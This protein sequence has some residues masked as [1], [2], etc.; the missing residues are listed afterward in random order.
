L[1]TFLGKQTTVV[2]NNNGANGVLLVNES[3]AIG[4]VA[5]RFAS[6][7]IL[8]LD[9]FTS[10][11]D[12]VRI[13]NYTLATRAKHSG[14]TLEINGVFQLSAP[15]GGASLT[16]SFVWSM[17]VTNVTLTTAILLAIDSNKLGSLPVG[18]MTNLTGIIP[19]VASAI[20]KL[21]VSSLSIDS[22]ALQA[23]VISGFKSPG[24]QRVVAQ[25]ADAI[26]AA[27]DEIA[28]TALS[29]MIESM[30][31]N[32]LD[33]VI[34]SLL[35]TSDCQTTNAQQNNTFVD[36]RNMFLSPQVA[37]NYGAS[38]TAP[39]GDLSRMIKDFVNNQFLAVSPYTNLT[40]LAEFLIVPMTKQQSGIAG[41]IVNN[42]L[43]NVYK[44]VNFGHTPLNVQ[45]QASNVRIDNLQSL[46][47]PLFLFVPERN[48]P[49]TVNNSIGF[50]LPPAPI[51]MGGSFLLGLATDTTKIH[52]EFVASVEI[53]SGQ[54]LIELWAKISESRLF[55]F[56][57]Q[58][59]LNLD[60]W[61]ATIPA[62]T[63]D[64]YG[65][66]LPGS[67]PTISVPEIVMA[68]ASMNFTLDCT[69]CSGL[70]FNEL[71]RTLATN[72]GDE[73]ATASATELINY[74]LAL[75][76]KESSWIQNTLD[77]K[78]VDAPR[79][80]PHSPEYIPNATS[81]QYDALASVHVPD[82]SLH[83]ILVLVIA[84]ASL[85]IF[86]MAITAS[87]HFVVRKR[88]E[89]WVR[90]LTSEQAMA[91]H[92]AQQREEEQA[93]AMN[94]SSLSLFRSQSIPLFV[95]ILVPIIIVAN[96]GLF[97]S[98]HFNKGKSRLH[99]SKPTAFV[100]KSLSTHANYSIL[101]VPRSEFI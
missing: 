31:M 26:Y 98:G 35:N 65:M 78:L 66:R 80:C 42:D 81:L 90:S 50:G 25:S 75:A 37:Q 71:S 49:F 41:T 34:N 24:L 79:H 7:S 19:C 39:Y 91:V 40:G 87:V 85:T 3:M 100:K 10:F 59:L 12:L 15:N 96:I 9:S 22:L 72:V 93:T 95:R 73:L 82:S 54:A 67:D 33:G 89:H 64:N 21:Q 11:D 29:H 14:F 60:C 101:K 51:I 88:N 47:D 92:M 57:V 18:S 30:V 61:L 6:A 20:Y 83:Y 2:D 69:N 68:V 27:F 94:D 74:V 56:P 58:D 8:G 77:R 44:T 45:L 55:E 16:E 70:K 63:L 4:N 86:V 1:N 32:T 99:V 76:T 5:L 53:H 13:S 38:G 46:G 97:L 52:D 36:F 62:P 48:Q 43:V 84:V 28:T 17:G 23:P